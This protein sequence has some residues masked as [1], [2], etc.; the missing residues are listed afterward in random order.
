MALF[1]VAAGRLKINENSPVAASN[2]SHSRRDAVAVSL[3][4]SLR[5]IDLTVFSKAQ[6]F[7]RA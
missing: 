3:T 5:H 7:K 1:V 2:R 6:Q 4:L